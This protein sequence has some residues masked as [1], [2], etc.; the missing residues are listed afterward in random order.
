[1]KGISP[2]IGFVLIIAISVAAI[3]IAMN[4]GTP[5]IERSKEIIIYEEGKTNLKLIDGAINEILQEGD[6]SSR[7]INLKITDGKYIVNNRKV[8]FIMTTN[9]GIVAPDI[10][11]E[12][13]GLTVET[14][15]NEITVYIEYDFDFVDDK[16]IIKGT[17]QIIISNQD[18]RVSIS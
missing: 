1:M 9:R 18:D 17:E 3:G 2:L 8:E 15:G 5:A 16:E 4:I 11:K 14:V 12:E 6:G 7:K 10:V 13:D